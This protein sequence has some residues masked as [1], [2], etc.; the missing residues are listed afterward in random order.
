MLTGVVGKDPGYDPLAFIIAEAHKR[1][2]KIHAWLNP[3]RVSMDTQ[4]ETIASLKKTLSS[5]LLVF[6][7]YIK[8]GYVLPTTVLCLIQAYQRFVIGSPVLWLK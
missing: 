4:P 2:L 3:Y 8:I 6:M 1:N 7:F 5:P